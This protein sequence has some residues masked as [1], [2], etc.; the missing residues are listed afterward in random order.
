MKRFGSKQQE[1][2][3]LLI[4]L[5]RYVGDEF[6]LGTYTR[7]KYRDQLAALKDRGIIKVRSK[8][9]KG[10]KPVYYDAFYS[11]SKTMNPEYYQLIVGMMLAS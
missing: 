3:D 11:F 10:S 4:S 2:L 9:V 7:I 1:A 5:H 8:V 6:S